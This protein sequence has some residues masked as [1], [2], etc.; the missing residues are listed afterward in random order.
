MGVLGEL[1]AGDQVEVI[2][3]RNGESIKATATMQK[4]N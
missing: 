1:K 3:L 2:V 4:R